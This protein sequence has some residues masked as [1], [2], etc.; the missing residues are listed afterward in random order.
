[1]TVPNFGSLWEK[2]AR[3]EPWETPLL[4]P[5][6]YLAAP[7]PLLD[8]PPSVPNGPHLPPSSGRGVFFFN[9]F[10]INEWKCGGQLYYLYTGAKKF[11]KE[12][13]LMVKDVMLECTDGKWL[14]LL[15]SLMLLH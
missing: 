2:I 9:Y 10:H 1:V 12:L 4:P 11:K 13:G 3:G 8:L 7:L 15:A 5:D 6:Q 14:H